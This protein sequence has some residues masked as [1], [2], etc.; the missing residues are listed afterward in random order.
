M[1]AGQR[2]TGASHEDAQQHSAPPPDAL[3][4]GPYDAGDAHLYDQYEAAPPDTQAEVGSRSATGLILLLGCSCRQ[5]GTCM[6]IAGLHCEG[7][8][9]LCEGAAAD[10]ADDTKCIVSGQLLRASHRLRPTCHQACHIARLRQACAAD[11][12]GS[13]RLS[14]AAGGFPSGAAYP[15]RPETF[16]HL[17]EPV[18]TLPAAH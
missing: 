17:P 14:A 5:T 3:D 1:S 13:L 6:R 15:T 4:V 8:G 16:E 11:A 9:P 10:K 7:P 2:L 12:R 18:R